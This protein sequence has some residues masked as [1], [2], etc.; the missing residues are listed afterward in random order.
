MVGALAM[1][2]EMIP[3]SDK[4]TACNNSESHSGKILSPFSQFF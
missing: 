1:T 3:G 4:D 2:P